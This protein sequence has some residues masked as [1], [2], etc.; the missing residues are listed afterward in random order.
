M[1]SKRQRDHLSIFLI[2]LLSASLTAAQTH[3]QTPGSSS[4]LIVPGQSVGSLRLGDSRQRVQQLFPMKEHVDQEWSDSRDECGTVVNWVDLKAEGNVFVHIRGVEAF[5]I[6]SATARF[7]TADGLTV[8]ATPQQV[9]Q[10]YH[11]LQAFNLSNGTSE[12]EG[13]RPLVYWVDRNKGIAFAFAY[14][15]KKKSWY[16]YHIVVFTPRADI[17]PNPEA[18]SPSDRREL[19]PYSLNPDAPGNEDRR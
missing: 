15:R 11:G 1:D 17:C 14:Y 7:K 16:L 8:G 18:L 12:A 2:L 6:D 13:E 5:Q 4:A 10:H 19:S 9:R 3:S